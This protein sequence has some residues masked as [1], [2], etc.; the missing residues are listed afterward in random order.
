MRFE[1]DNRLY[2]LELLLLLL[3]L[4]PVTADPLY[5]SELPPPDASICLDAE[6]LR[7]RNSV[8]DRGRNSKRELE[9]RDHN[10]KTHRSQSRRTEMEEEEERCRERERGGKGGEKVSDPDMIKAARI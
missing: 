10:P 4:L 2:L 1:A 9:V 6:N 8:D 5:G 3:P 7:E